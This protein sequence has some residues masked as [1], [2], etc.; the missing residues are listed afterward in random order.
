[1]L[2]NQQ[3]FQTFTHFRRIFSMKL[4]KQTELTVGKN[5]HLT[6]T[7][8]RFEFQFHSQWSTHKLMINDSTTTM[9]KR[10]QEI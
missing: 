8:F 5:Q 4:A 2:A 1:M 10:A 9:A 7:H 6:N 3:M